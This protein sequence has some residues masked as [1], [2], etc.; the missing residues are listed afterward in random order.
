MASNIDDPPPDDSDVDLN[1]VDEVLKEDKV[2][3]LL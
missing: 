1:E 2:L 3:L